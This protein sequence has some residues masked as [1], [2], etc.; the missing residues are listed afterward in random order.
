MCSHLKRIT[1]IAKKHCLTSVWIIWQW[2]IYHL[3]WPQKLKHKPV[4]SRLML[5]GMWNA[6]CDYKHRNLAALCRPKSQSRLKPAQELVSLKRVNVAAVR[7]GLKYE[8]HALKDFSARYG[9]VVKRSGIVI[10]QERPHIAG[11]PD[12]LCDEYVV[13]VKCPYS[14]KHAVITPET[15]PYLYLDEHTGLYTLDSSHNYYYQIQGLM[16]ITGKSVLFYRL[17]FV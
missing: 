3:S 8:Q 2:L 1:I 10:S 11:S 9:V 12:G 13:E 16:Y 15:V 5:S 14:A 17:H 6:A 4:A 7:H